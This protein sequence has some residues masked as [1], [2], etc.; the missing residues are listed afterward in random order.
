MKEGSR[1]TGPL[2]SSDIEKKLIK[3]V[4]D[5]S[6]HFELVMKQIGILIGKN[7][8]LENKVESLEKEIKA[9]R[10]KV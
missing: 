8:I 7:K 5:H 10:M 6:A 2:D 1:L 3:K 9:I 4:N